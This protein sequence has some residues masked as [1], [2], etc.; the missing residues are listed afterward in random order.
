M[1]AADV[2]AGPPGSTYDGLCTVALRYSAT[3]STPTVHAAGSW[4]DFSPTADELVDDGAG[5][6]T[7]TLELAPGL[8]PYKLVVEGDGAEPWRL[9]PSNSYRAYAG[10]VENSGLRVPDC[11]RPTLLVDSSESSRPTEGD[12]RFS[13][14]LHYERREAGVFGELRA[15][16]RSAE[17]P[18]PL[19]DGEIT[20]TGDSVRVSLEGLP[21]GKYTVALTPV[22][23]E[24]TAGPAAL[25]PFWVE[26]STFHWRDALI[27]LIMTDRF[28]DG[29]ASNDVPAVGALPGAEFEGGDLRGVRQAIEEG[30][31][32]NLGVNA[33]WVTPWNTQPAGAYDEAGGT[34]GVTGYHG[35]W[36]T[37]PRSIDARFGDA[38][39]LMA[40]VNAAHAHG[41]RVLMDLVVN[42]VHQDHPY[43]RDHPDWFNSGC[44]CG[45]AGCDWTERRL[46]CLFRDYLPD[47]NWENNDAG[48]QL[49]DDAE[50]WLEAYDLDGFRVDAV[51]HVVDGAVFNLRARV[52]ERFEQ[53]GTHYFLMGETAMGWD[54][55]AGPD[56]GGNVENYGTISRYIGPDALDGQFDFVLYYAGALSFAGDA[57]GRGMSHVDFWTRASQ[58]HYPAGAI[59]TPYLGSHDT[60][61]WLSLASDPGRAGNK[62]SDLPVAPS[63]SEAYDRMYV[64]FGWLM[65]LPG[66]PLLY[67]G[68]E[69]GEFGGADPDNRHMLRFGSDLSALESAQ[70]TRTAAL[71]RARADLPGL[72]SADYRPLLVTDDVWIVARGRGADLV[73]VA[74]NR[75]AAAA[76]LSV[77]VPVDVAADGRTFSDA[78]GST[79]SWALARQNLDLSLPP[80]SVRYLR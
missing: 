44:I 71:G 48:E 30:Y 67:M 61:R 77:P 17:A 41:I 27:Y 80:R 42:H 60:S 2:D 25:L 54:S 55:G 13:A 57:P 76:T 14:A 46:D 50:Y 68:D 11:S 21:D 6:Y 24:G 26:A 53:A 64:A 19:S 16:L 51:K 39:E 12:G 3:G 20:R 4:N 37:E 79:G 62:W 33:I 34:G 18:R 52:R 73:I 63:T 8:Y 47:V 75:G 74:L 43:F 31:L 35:Y 29:D 7:A 45:T 69:Y 59:M 36:P 38:A 72:R 49:L 28:R 32:D 10:G 58:S 65:A 70:L 78:L 23:V 22:D 40:M 15:E 5:E 1:D 66:A 9:D 56:A